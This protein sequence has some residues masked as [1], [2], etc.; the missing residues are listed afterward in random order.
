MPGTQ[1]S[2]QCHTHCGQ[3]HDTEPQKSRNKDTSGFI[4]GSRAA[5]TPPQTPCQPQ[6]RLRLLVG[7]LSQQSPQPLLSQRTGG[8]LG[9]LTLTLP[10]RSFGLIKAA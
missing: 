8:S 4:C 6:T 2:A 3:R 9:C 1:S 5:Q 7:P 10:L